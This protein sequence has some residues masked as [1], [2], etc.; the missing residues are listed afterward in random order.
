MLDE[1]HSENK[2]RDERHHFWVQGEKEGWAGA[3]LSGAPEGRAGWISIGRWVAGMG[4]RLLQAGE[5]S[6]Q[7]T[8]ES[9]CPVGWGWRVLVGDHAVEKN[10][11]K[12]KQIAAAIY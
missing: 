12:G 7:G 4:E 2:R 9:K 3:S 5:E 1:K 6:T 11:R 8:E 10:S